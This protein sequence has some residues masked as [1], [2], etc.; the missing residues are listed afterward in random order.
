MFVAA[1]SAR[2]A[3]SVS[4]TPTRPASCA[5]I[6]CS[7]HSLHRIYIPMFLHGLLSG[8]QG[9]SLVKVPSFYILLMVY[10]HDLAFNAPI[11]F[12]MILSPIFF[13]MYG[14]I[15]THLQQIYAVAWKEFLNKFRDS[16]TRKFSKRYYPVQ[17]AS[18]GSNILRR[19]FGRETI[20]EDLQKSKLGNALTHMNTKRSYLHTKKD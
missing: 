14:T 13:Y 1:N 10:N 9:L 17:M 12:I 16:C 8:S 18:F 7:S 2:S 6:V 4:S 15:N 3:A 20:E 11:Y 19:S 5:Y